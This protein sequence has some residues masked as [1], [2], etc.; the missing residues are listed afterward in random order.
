ML[1]V[2]MKPRDPIILLTRPKAAADLFVQQLKDA[3][4]KSKVLVSSVQ[5]IKR[6]DFEEPVAL[7]G[8]IF[9]SRNGV[10]A[11]TGREAPCWC[12]GA[13]TADAARAKGWQAV[14]SQGDAEAVFKRITA[15]R[16]KGTLVHFRGAFA[17]G[18]LAERLSDEG[19]DTREVVVYSQVSLPLSD[20]A[21]EMFAR[22][23]PVIL[24]LFSPRSAAQLVQ[25][26]PF[27]APLW[28]IAM[29]DAVAGEAVA[30]SP[31]HM[32][33]SATPD[34]IGM[35][36]AIKQMENTAYGIES[37]RNSF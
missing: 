14:S 25:Q 11:V 21:R 4:I 9:T 13:A 15:E 32:E 26:G 3:G 12:V 27:T 34:A 23:N 19:I 35:V 10:E 30:L 28:I 33:I 8:A 36:A 29:S 31:V 5:G 20:P 1:A 6:A 17:R 18:N 16:P 24:P 22:E 37:E 7:A 2:M